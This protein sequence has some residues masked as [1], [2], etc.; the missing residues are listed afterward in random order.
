MAKRE[1]YHLPFGR[2]VAESP[3]DQLERLSLPITE[4]GCWAW[5][6]KIGTH[7]YADMSYRIAPQQRVT[8]N[9]AKV[10]WEIANAAE[11][12]KHLELDHI[13]HSRWCVNPDHLRA[14]T[15]SVNIRSRRPFDNRT[16]GGYC[17]RGHLLPPNEQRN[18]NQSCPICYVH[19][20]QEWR[21]RNHARLKEYERSRR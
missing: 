8:R 2:Q 6:G 17:K 3:Q 12:P 7:G 20:Q 14:V 13:C 1:T 10:A 15:H 18:G 16:Y 19:N 9:A 5:L 4:C 11:F 21:K